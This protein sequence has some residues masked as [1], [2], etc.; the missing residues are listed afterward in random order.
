MK[1]QE[2]FENNAPTTKVKAVRMMKFSL[3]NGENSLGLDLANAK[4]DF[5]DTGYIFYIGKK[6]E[7]KVSEEYE[8]E[9]ADKPGFAADGN[10]KL[11]GY[12]RKIKDIVPDFA[13]FLKRLKDERNPKIVVNPELLK[14]AK[15]PAPKAKAEEPTTPEDGYFLLASWADP[16]RRGNDEWFWSGPFFT[17]KEAQDLFKRK[18]KNGQPKTMRDWSE[19]SS[20]VI[21]GVDKFVEAAKKVDLNPNVSDLSFHD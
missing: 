13:T 21:R 14:D 2:L 20:K 9:N 11:T 12:A 15:A 16:Y 17:K 4:C 6:G 5:Y 18:M 3:R 1:V 10:N 19:G 7:L 8:F